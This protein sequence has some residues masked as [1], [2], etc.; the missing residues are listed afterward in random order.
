MYQTEYHADAVFEKGR[1]VSSLWVRDR[2]TYRLLSCYASCHT[3]AIKFIIRHT[4]PSSTSTP[5]IIPLIICAKTKRMAY[6]PC[7]N[8]GAGWASYLLCGLGEKNRRPGGR[9]VPDFPHEPG[10]N[11][12][13]RPAS[14]RCAGQNDHCSTGVLLQ[15]LRSRNYRLK[16]NESKLESHAYFGDP[17]GVL[18]ER[19][20][21]PVWWT[22]HKPLG[23][24]AFFQE[25]LDELRTRCIHMSVGG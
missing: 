9:F 7:L 20:G 4:A 25:V 18:K 8:Y 1:E 11:R 2:T 14:V 5:T 22:S 3:S 23:A 6:Y 19:E 21:V 16:E 15:P 10:F 24:A 13:R 17:T 12:R